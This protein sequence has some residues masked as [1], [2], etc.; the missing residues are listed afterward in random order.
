MLPLNVDEITVTIEGIG[1][2]TPITEAGF[3][4]W[5]KRR[6]IILGYDDFVVLKKQYRRLSLAFNSSAD[7]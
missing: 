5:K 6:K 7:M 3:G 4:I 1:S 2:I